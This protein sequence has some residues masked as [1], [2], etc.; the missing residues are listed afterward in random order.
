MSHVAALWV[1]SKIKHPLDESL[2]ER[3]SP[4]SVVLQALLPLAQ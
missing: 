4:K 3:D 1:F 2:G